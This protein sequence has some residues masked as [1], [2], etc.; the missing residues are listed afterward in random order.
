MTSDGLTGGDGSAGAGGRGV[1][2]GAGHGPRSQ[3]LRGHL[4]EVPEED[5]TGQRKHR[6]CQCATPLRIVIDGLSMQRQKL[7]HGYLK[8]VNSAQLVCETNIY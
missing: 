7:L 2:D 1:G 6:R 5:M 3:A 4:V 8:W